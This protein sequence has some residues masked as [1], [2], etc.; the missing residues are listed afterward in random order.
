MGDA[1]SG[2]LDS[3]VEFAKGGKQNVADTGVLE[4]ARSRAADYGGDICAALNA[5]YQE[6]RCSGDSDKADKVK[7]TQK[8]MGCR[9]SGGGG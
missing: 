6:A 3:I 5:M 7:A 1:V 2:G 4:E 8:A 9:R